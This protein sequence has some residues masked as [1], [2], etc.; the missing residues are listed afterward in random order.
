MPVLLH[1]QHAQLRPAPHKS[2][3]TQIDGNSPAFWRDGKLFLFS[4]TGNPEMLSEADSQFGPWNSGEVDVNE[5]HLPAW[6]EAAWLD[7]DGAIYVWYHHEPGGVCPSG[8]SLTAPKIGAG[9]SYD[10]GRTIEDLGIVLESGYPPDCSA[11]NGFFAGGHGD[12]SVVL[13]PNREYFYF[14]FTNYSGPWW[15]QGI[16]TARMRFED[17]TDPAGKV[18]KYFQGFWDEPGLG[19]RTM[20]VFTAFKSWERADAD[21]Y[22]GPAVHWNTHLNSYV[23]LLNRACCE[24]GWPQEG[25]YVSF[26]RDLSEPLAWGNPAR[27]IE[28]SKIGHAPGYYP[29][30]LGLAPGETDTIAGQTARFYIHGESDWEIVFSER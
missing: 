30:V 10:G 23:M 28:G 19:G 2:L 20:P 11:K 12:F 18:L 7:G 16:A 13:D 26:N 4:S 17:R 5:A 21:S 6:V 29:Q 22:W 9:V 27:L 14:F 25:I 24:P 15:E 8:S 1:G 3:P